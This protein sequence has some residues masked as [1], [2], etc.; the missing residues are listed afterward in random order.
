[1][2]IQN[3]V[4]K[5]EYSSEEIKKRTAIHK[6]SKRKNE[7]ETRKGLAENHLVRR[8]NKKETTFLNVWGKSSIAN[9]ESDKGKVRREKG[10]YRV[11]SL[12]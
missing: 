2:P 4:G 6:T 5:A 1:V 7:S 10:V 3:L 8:T 11:A 9:K 12:T